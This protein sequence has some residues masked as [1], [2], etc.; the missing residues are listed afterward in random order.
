LKEELQLL[1]KANNKDSSS[2]FLEDT[3]WLLTLAYLADIY[4]HLNT[5]N[6]IMHG[7]K[8]HILTSTDKI[9]AFKNKIQVWK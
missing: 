5:L 3:K 7:S 2:N 9:L 4:Q 6:I 8:E 1:N